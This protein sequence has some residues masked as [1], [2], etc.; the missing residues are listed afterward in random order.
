[1]LTS[2][3]IKTTSRSAHMISADVSIKVLQPLSRPF[4]HPFLIDKALY[5]I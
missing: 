2:A 1:M 4:F 5:I 3:D